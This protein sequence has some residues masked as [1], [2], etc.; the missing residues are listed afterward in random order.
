MVLNKHGGI[1]T[2]QSDNIV[3]TTQHEFSHWLGTDDDACTK[4]QRCVMTSDHINI[5][6]DNCT[7]AIFEKLQGE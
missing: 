1:V 2:Q 4:D 7:N 5:W 3:R 6:C